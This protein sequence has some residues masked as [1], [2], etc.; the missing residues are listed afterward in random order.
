MTTEERTERLEI[1]M[2]KLI[3]AL[4]STADLYG[5]INF[6]IKSNKDVAEFLRDIMLLISESENKQNENS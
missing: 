4:G 2:G 6:L 1:M 5:T 3:L